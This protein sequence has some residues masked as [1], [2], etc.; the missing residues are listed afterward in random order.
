MIFDKI[1]E[2]ISYPKLP[3][4]KTVDL[5]QEHEGLLPVGIIESS[6]RSIIHPVLPAL[7]EFC[8]GRRC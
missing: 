5:F 1:S 8:F 6:E 4:G 7:V 2:V 3:K